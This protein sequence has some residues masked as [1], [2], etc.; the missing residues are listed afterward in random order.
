MNVDPF[1]DFSP[2]F[3]DNITAIMTKKGELTSKSNEN[4]LADC[5]KKAGVNFDS[6]AIPIQTHSDHVK[7]V[8][9]S[10]NVTDTD[11]LI[12]D[13]TNIILTLSVADCVPVFMCDEKTG[14]FGLIHSGW[15]GTAKNIVGKAVDQFKKISSNSDDISV[16]TGPSI[17][18][19]C[20]EFG[21]D[22]ARYFKRDALIK[23]KK[24]KWLLDLRYV[25]TNQLIDSGIPENRIL[26]DDRCTLESEECESFRRDGIDAGRMTALMWKSN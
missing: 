3:G 24:D 19:A 1:F 6:A 2:N 23:L 25:I 13:Q 14:I 9:I 16:L 10:G 18:G 26:I 5:F 8:S 21:D 7:F 22:S 12:T 17:C 11:G 15:K 4:R 20:Y